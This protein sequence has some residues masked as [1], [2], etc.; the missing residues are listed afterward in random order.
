MLV[1]H[2]SEAKPVTIILKLALVNKL[3]FVVKLMSKEV[4]LTLGIICCWKARW[5]LPA[6]MSAAQEIVDLLSWLVNVAKSKS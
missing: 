5:L 1:Q 3:L 4:T 6:F 2:L